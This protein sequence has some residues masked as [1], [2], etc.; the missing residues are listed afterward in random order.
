MGFL[1]KIWAFILDIAQTI[2]LAAS[3]FLVIY[4]FFFRPFQVNGASMLPSFEDKEYVLTNIFILHFENPKVGDVVVF[5]SPTEPDK[6]FIK[7]VIAIPG[8]TISLR[9]GEVYINSQKLDQSEYVP[10][11]V[12]TSEGS[13]LAEGESITVPNDSYFVMGDNRLHSSD[14]R[15]WGFVKKSEIIGKS[16]FVY[17]PLNRMRLVKNP[18]QK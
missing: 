15:Q 13:F 1:S 9:S 4:I 12:Q 14:S 10:N 11:Y 6:D 17:W 8:D 18:Y 3:V 5:K 7:R 2:L 16:L